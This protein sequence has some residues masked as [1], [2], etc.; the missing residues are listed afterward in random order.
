MNALHL[1]NIKIYQ[2]V[3]QCGGRVLEVN[4]KWFEREGG[5]NRDKVVFRSKKS[6]ESLVLVLKICVVIASREASRTLVPK[7]L[8]VKKIQNIQKNSAFFVGQMRILKPL[9]L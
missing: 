3:F 6:F 7:A 9:K 4:V 2:F 1:P 5:E 8:C